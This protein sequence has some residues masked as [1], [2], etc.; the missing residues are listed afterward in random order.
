[1]IK[2]G[3]FHRLNAS[4]SFAF[5][6]AFPSKT[7]TN[8]AVRMQIASLRHRSRRKRL[9][10]SSANERAPRYHGD[11]LPCLLT[12]LISAWLEGRQRQNAFAGVNAEPA[13]GDHVT[14]SIGHSWPLGWLAGR[15]TG[16]PT[17]RLV[18]PTSWL[19][20]D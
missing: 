7:P 18:W 6:L 13:R 8:P 1:M 9:F 20:A 11:W 19:T 14:K 4:T 15:P 16:R 2:R 17:D 3:V 12:G 5:S 10:P